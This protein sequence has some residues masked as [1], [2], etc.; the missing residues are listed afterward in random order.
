MNWTRLFAEVEDARRRTL[1]LIGDLTNEQL[2]GPRLPTVS[3]LLW[4]VGHVGWFEERWV[5]REALKRAPL[6]DDLDALYDPQ[7][8]PRETRWDVALPVRTDM[9]D[10]LERVQEQVVEALHEGELDGE[11]AAYLAMAL[12]HEDA[13]GEQMLAARQTMRYPEPRLQ[14][15]KA[16]WPFAGPLPGDAHVPGGKF[17]LGAEPGRLAWVHDNEQWAHEV[18]VKPFRISRAAVTQA[19]FAAFVT[20]G[21]Y[22][23]RKYWSD[24][25]WKW[26]AST[27]AAHPLYWR[28]V[29][30]G[31]ERR[32]FERWLPLEPHRPVIHVNWFEAE[33][34]C[35]FVD[36]RLP[37]ELEWEVA[38]AGE[39][40][41][42]GGLAPKKR[43]YPWGDE[44]PT[45]ERAALDARLFGAVDVGALA[46]GDSAFGC[47]QMIGSTWEWTQSDFVP[48]PGFAPGPVRNYSEPWFGTRKVLRGGSW[49]TR[50]RLI[51]NEWRAF[52]TPD[53][54][55][56]FT[57]FRT[58]AL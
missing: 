53:R 24:E 6:H 15:P 34:Y 14:Q 22:R 48:Y 9:I 8:V 30:D 16:R 28:R 20:E 47:R 57:G 41:G 2:W 52:H 26:L 42:Q 35:R 25:G 55:D 18:E 13:H 49:A 17:R 5:L 32:D 10:Y 51:H 40:D 50:S 29:H 58:C 54:R 38:A 23:E 21:G 7:A 33:A 43:L 31:W 46:A 19:E 45:P 36:R 12:S 39:P 56:L 27:G 11:K 4:E 44:L 1:E 37:T 3:P